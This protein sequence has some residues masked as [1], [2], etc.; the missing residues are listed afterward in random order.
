MSTW[1]TLSLRRSLRSTAAATL[2]A[3]APDGL[4]PARWAAYV[5]G[6]KV[7]SGT[8]EGTMGDAKTAADAWLAGL[9]AVAV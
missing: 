7:A 9:L 5:G 4:A 6:R 2:H 8:V 1:R 3:T